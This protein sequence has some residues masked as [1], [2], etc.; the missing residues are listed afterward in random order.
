[1]VISNKDFDG[2]KKPI[3]IEEERWIL[4]NKIVKAIGF[5]LTTIFAIAGSLSIICQYSILLDIYVYSFGIGAYNPPSHIY[6]Y[7]KD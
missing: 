7:L 1:M 5:T 4:W 3:S 2:I 6:I